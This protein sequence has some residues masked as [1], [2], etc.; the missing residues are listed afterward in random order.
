MGVAEGVGVGVAG[1]GVGVRDGVGVTA[2]VSE[3][4]AVIDGVRV[5]VGDAGT[6]VNVGA[7]VGEAVGEAVAVTGPTG[8]GVMDAVAVGL[9]ILVGTSPT[10]SA[11]C[12]SAMTTTSGSGN[13]RVRIH[14]QF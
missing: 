8:D 12:C 6:V 3:G 2:G 9:G 1:P 4:V 5:S 13:S 11:K 10:S 14:S 7:R